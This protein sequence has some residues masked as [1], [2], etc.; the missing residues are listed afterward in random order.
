[1]QSLQN[2]RTAESEIFVT[3]RRL[4]VQ[5]RSKGCIL[6]CSFTEK[7]EKIRSVP[8][9]MKLIRI[10]VPMFWLGASPPNFDKIIESPSYLENIL[11]MGHSVEE[12]SMSRDIVIFLLQH[13]GFVI[14]WKR[15]V[16]TP[17]QEISIREEKM[18]K[19]KTKCQNL[20]AEPATSILELIRAIGL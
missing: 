7:L 2:V 16:L 20:L 10:F 8:L 4:H 11:L 6:F 15:S 17:A 5:A 19:V 14:N 9:V 18:Q 13:L 3:R 1:M 12:I